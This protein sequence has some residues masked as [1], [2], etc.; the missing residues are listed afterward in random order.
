MK[1][2][3]SIITP[4][5]NT[6][7]FV[8]QTMDSVRNQTYTNWEMLIVDDCSTDG[9]AEVIENY[10]KENG[11][12]R[13]RLLRNQRNSGAALSR[14]YALR[15]AKGRWV[16]FLDSD[17]LWTPDKLEKQI[18]FMQDMPCS[19]SYTEYSE[20][21][22][23]SRSLGRTVS[24]PHRITRM[25]MRRYCWPGCLTVMYDRA[26]IGLVQ[27][28]NIRKNNDYAMWLAISREAPCC[29]LAENLGSYRKRS[30]SISNHN[31]LKLIQWHYRLFHD[32]EGR[33]C[34]A[35]LYY[36]AGNLFFGLYKKLRYYR[37]KP[38]EDAAD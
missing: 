21:D 15:E 24:G 10:L 4:S 28:P 29:L 35:S 2:L 38:G 33:N 30:G 19:F 32:A 3:V 6:A 36:T 11:E 7:G 26:A 22:E 17:D 9:S 1:E 23:Q 8:C 16:A 13:I 12:T 18:R 34:F 5:Y 27:C 14:N 37:K 20:I 25:G 31:C